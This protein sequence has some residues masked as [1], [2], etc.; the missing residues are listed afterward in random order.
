[1]DRCHRFIKAVLCL[2][3]LISYAY[4]QKPSAED[5]CSRFKESQDSNESQTTRKITDGTAGEC[6]LIDVGKH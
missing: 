3:F 2:L 5:F 4:S 1:M 6:E